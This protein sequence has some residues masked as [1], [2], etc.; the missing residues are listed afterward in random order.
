M[1]SIVAW[2]SP[3]R[4]DVLW[5]RVP[6]RIQLYIPAVFVLVVAVVAPALPALV[7]SVAVALAALWQYRL[8]QRSVNGDDGVSEGWHCSDHPQVVWLWFMLMALSR[9]VVARWSRRYR[10]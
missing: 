10:A 5:R 4:A 7:T 8:Y 1:N 6:L 9:R 2:R 3:F